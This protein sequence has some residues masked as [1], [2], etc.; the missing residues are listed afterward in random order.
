MSVRVFLEE[1]RSAHW[2]RHC[3]SHCGWTRHR[4]ATIKK[5]NRIF[6]V[7]WD[8]QLLLPAV[9]NPPT[10][11]PWG[12]NQDLPFGLL[13]LEPSG[14]TYVQLSCTYSL[15]SGLSFINTWCKPYCRDLL[16][17]PIYPPSAVSVFLERSDVWRWFQQS[18]FKKK[19]KKERLK[20]SR[21]T[22][23]ADHLKLSWD[24]PIPIDSVEWW[25]TIWNQ[26]ARFKTKTL[27][28]IGQEFQHKSLSLGTWLGVFLFG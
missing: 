8:P 13:T 11:G 27:I 26:K 2:F 18:H 9:V 16:V 25:E 24:E 28:P 12:W 10:P 7:S 15:E 21:L 19:R 20:R 14:L 17:C 22:F 6:F 3:R 5:A 23:E 1:I 4:T